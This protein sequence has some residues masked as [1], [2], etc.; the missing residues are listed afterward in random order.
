MPTRKLGDLAQVVRSK[1]AKPFRITFDV[2]FND[3]A[4]YERVKAAKVLTPQRI[5]QLYGVGPDEILS[6]HEFDAGL[7]IKFTLRRRL[8]Q[9]APGDTDVYGCQQHAPLLDIEVPWS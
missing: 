6:L 2:I 4:T 8:A 9:G 5:V 7:A 3:R 1:N